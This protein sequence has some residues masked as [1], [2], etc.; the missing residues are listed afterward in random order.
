M[1]K[2]PAP[3]PMP[4]RAA[5]SDQSY[6][7]RWFELLDRVEDRHFWFVAR[8]RV[9]SALARQAV[10]D[11]RPGYRVLEIGCGNGGLLP[12]LR[13]ACAGGFVI[14]A[15]LHRDALKH[16]RRRAA[17]IALVQCDVS[18]PPFES[19]FRLIGMFDV[20]EHLVDDIGALRDVHRLLEPDGALLITVPAHAWLWSYFDEASNHQR[21][22]SISDLREKLSAA[23]FRIA[24][25]SQFMMPLLPIM[26]L[27]RRSKRK[28]RADAAEELRIV[29]GINGIMRALLG[30]ETKLIA[31][32]KRLQMGTSLVALAYKDP[33]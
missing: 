29:P 30:L 32:R 5:V 19:R 23:G 11:A 14:G 15:E 3:P 6:D 20:L 18:R 8:R 21:R 25:L 2:Q 22:Y 17:D 16:A 27:T 24:Y 33:G 26:W 4:S 10:A 9:V 1:V 31:R 28:T 7:P 12:T 13:Q